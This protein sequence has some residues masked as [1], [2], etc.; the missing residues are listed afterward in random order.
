MLKEHTCTQE[1]IPMDR[2]TDF[3]TDPKVPNFL[4]REKKII[5][6]SEPFSTVTR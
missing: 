6:G 1:K 2:P 3:N 5:D 4:E